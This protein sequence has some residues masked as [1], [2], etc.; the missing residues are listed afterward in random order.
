MRKKQESGNKEKISICLPSEMLEVLDSYCEFYCMSRSSA[1]GYL[2]ATSLS[3]E[4]FKTKGFDFESPYVIEKMPNGEDY[5]LKRSDVLTRE[6]VGEGWIFSMVN[7]AKRFVVVSES[8]FSVTPDKPA[9]FDLPPRESDK[10]S[11]ED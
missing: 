11:G 2:L 9:K 7:K 5:I 10:D 1:I 3:T 6:T 4:S 8:D